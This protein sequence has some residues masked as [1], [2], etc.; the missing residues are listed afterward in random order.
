MHDWKLIALA[1]RI[2]SQILIPAQR[3]HAHRHPAAIPNL[4][5]GTPAGR[6]VHDGHRPANAS[7][8]VRLLALGARP[9]AARHEHDPDV[10]PEGAGG[11]EHEEGNNRGG[12][13][14][15]EHGKIASGCLGAEVG[16]GGDVGGVGGR[17]GAQL[18]GDDDDLEE[19]C[20]GGG[21]S[22]SGMEGQEQWSRDN[23]RTSGRQSQH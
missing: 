22:A 23:G 2:R 8:L 17:G 12:N 1:I 18:V 21:K 9:D 10:L 15:R 4:Q 6:G 14:R 13:A 5:I 11:A 16:R 20:A 19:A 7:P 3:I